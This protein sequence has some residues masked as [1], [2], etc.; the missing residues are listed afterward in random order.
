VP[1]RI[2]PEVG[3]ARGVL[4]RSV[5]TGASPA[6]IA[7]AKAELKRAGLAE[8]IKRDVSTWPPLTPEVRAELAVLL[9]TPAGDSDD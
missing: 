4:A 6:R 2:D 1:R 5:Q 7:E 9:L 8:R 3:H